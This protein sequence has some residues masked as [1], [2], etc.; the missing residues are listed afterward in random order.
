MISLSRAAA[1]LL[2]RGAVN[3]VATRAV[4]S[5]AGGLFA[6]AYQRELVVP[7]GVTVIGVGGATL[8]GSWK[9]P[10]AIA[11]AKCLA[12]RGRSVLF[13]SHGYGRSEAVVR[14]VAPSDSIALSGDEAVLASRQLALAGVPV[15][16]E[17]ASYESI[18]RR[19]KRGSVIVV[20]GLTR[21]A[22]DRSQRHLLCLD[23][24]E[25]WGAGACPPAGDLR[26][27]IDRMLA[28]SSER[29]LIADALAQPSPEMRGA[30]FARFELKLPSFP[31]AS[32]LLLV[33][34][35]ARPHRLL[36]ALARRGVRPAD[37]VELPDH[38]SARA[39]ARLRERLERHCSYDAIL[40]TE[41]CALHLG[42]SVGPL[43]VLTIGLEL[44]L[45]ETL[46]SALAD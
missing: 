14:L 45:P 32:R 5:A 20:D 9:T 26:A 24:E 39:I 22:R 21:G 46:L 15:L 38:G 12:E 18:M 37:V 36:R 44:A 2:E 34:A 40:A 11:L 27:P 8:G 3:N 25:P 6:R 30:H 31:A 42:A 41:K 16:V 10:T 19:A 23:A 4:A 28:A 13:A 7:E 43:D 29:L 1:A 17:G 35:I 33:T